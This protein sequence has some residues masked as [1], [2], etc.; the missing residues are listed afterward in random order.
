MKDAEVQGEE[1]DHARDETNP[2]PGSDFN[3]CEH[4]AS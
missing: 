1:N 4:A 2:M 3:Q